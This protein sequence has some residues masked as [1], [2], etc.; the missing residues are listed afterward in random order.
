MSRLPRRRRAV[1]ML[2]LAL[3]CGGLAASEVS[4][5]VQEV[6]SRVGPPVPVVVASEDIRAGTSLRHEEVQRSLTIT[7]VPE[8]FVPPDAL[9][10]PEDALG[11]RTA[12]SVS[13][14]GY[15]TVGH[16]E[17]G[18]TDGS[19]GPLLAPGERV[20]EVVV[21][22]GDAVAAAG[23]GV[24][25]DV[26]ITT[27]EGAAG[28]TYVALED[29]ELLGIQPGG[30]AGGELGAGGSIASLRVTVEQAVRLTAA[31]NFAREI[32]LLA[33]SPTDRKQLGPT[34]VAAGEL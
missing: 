31:Q 17:T 29:V 33:R 11:L 14:G 32:R 2:A 8:R 34:S 28:R 26:L 25:V 19:R 30:D 27:G 18:V 16:L 1:V 7:E 21:A 3:A 9:A 13:A 23:P 15:V 4:S 12:V 24:R 6:E 22:G 20:T 5:S 10:A